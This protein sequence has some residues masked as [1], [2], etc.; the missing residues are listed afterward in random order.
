MAAGPALLDEM[1]R[2]R[3][4][5]TYEMGELLGVSHSTVHRHLEE[6]G[7]E[8]RRPGAPGSSWLTEA[9]RAALP[10]SASAGPRCEGCGSTGHVQAHHVVPLAAGGSH[11]P[12]N[13]MSLCPGCHGRAHAFL[14]RLGLERL[15]A[16]E[17][18]G[19]DGA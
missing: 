3:G 14:R 2:A 10:G 18:P 12:G 1:Y 4:M 5:T 6:H 7:I 15:G 11:H 16:L 13:V 19:G 17:A 8:R 9:L